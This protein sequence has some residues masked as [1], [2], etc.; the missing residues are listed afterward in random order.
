MDLLASVAL[1]PVSAGPTCNT[2]DFEEHQSH[3][4]PQPRVVNSS[5]TLRTASETDG[6]DHSSCTTSQATSDAGTPQ[7]SHGSAMAPVAVAAEQQHE[8][9]IETLHNIRRRIPG[10]SL[11]KSMKF[12][13][14]TPTTVVV[15]RPVQLEH[16]SLAWLGMHNTCNA[17]PQMQL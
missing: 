14:T 5:P 6:Q 3:I 12:E 4:M 8:Q 7:H 13:D 1:S 2:L 9:K 17:A 11:L 10:Q 15:S 16:Q